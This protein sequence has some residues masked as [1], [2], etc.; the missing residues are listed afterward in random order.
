MKK[1]MLAG[2]MAA[3]ILWTT[4]P[5][6]AFQEDGPA[7][8]AVALA[9]ADGDTRYG[10]KNVLGEDATSTQNARR[11]WVDH[12]VSTK[13]SLTFDGVD[14][15][16]ITREAGEDFLVTYST[17]AST[18]E[19][20]ILPD[21][22]PSDTIFVLDFSMTM[23]RNMIGEY[24]TDE[25]FDTTRTK[26][27]LDAM[28]ET[29]TTLKEANGDNRVGI[30]TFCG[31]SDVLLPLTRLG[32]ITEI[33]DT[34]AEADINIV[35]SYAG[36]KK[37]IYQTEHN[38]FSVSESI[39]GVNNR[40][41]V[42]C[43]I[44]G[45][46]VNM[47][48]DW[49]SMFAGLYEALDML[50][51]AN[52]DGEN[53][54]DREVHIVVITDGDSNAVPQAVDGSEWYEKLDT[55]KYTPGGNGEAGIVFATVLMASYLKY[56]M[57]NH[58]SDCSIYTVG[59]ATNDSMRLLLDTNEYI[60]ARPADQ[61][62]KQ[63]TDYWRRYQDGTSPQ[64][65]GITFTA[66][67]DDKGNIVPESYDYVD[68]FFDTDNAEDLAD[69]F[70]TIT[71]EIIL[72]EAQAPAEVPDGA[73]PAQSGYVTYTAPLGEYMEV[74][75]VK[76]ILF[77][78]E[79]FTEKTAFQSGDTT[80][81]VFEGKVDSPVYDEKPL[82]D[83]VIQEDN[84]PMRIVYSVGLMNEVN[85]ETLAGVSP[86]Y[87]ENNMDKQGNVLFY[88]NGYGNQEISEDK[89][90]GSVTAQ[91]T[92]GNTNPFYYAPAGTVL[93]TCKNDD[94]T[95]ATEYKEGETYYV[96]QDYYCKNGDESI[97]NLLWLN[98]SDLKKDDTK[99]EALE[100]GSEQLVLSRSILKQVHMEDAR[101]EKNEGNHS[102]TADY[103]Y[104][105]TERAGNPGE[106]LAYLGNNGRLGLENPL[107]ELAIS[108]TVQ[109][110]EGKNLPENA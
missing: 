20:S 67:K 102:E 34:T 11:M 90:V 41:W 96:K 108:K 101:T 84:A 8:P 1:R 14:S 107:G 109:A 49:T 38:Y 37:V 16:P 85:R 59:L 21:N 13:N 30:V 25:A 47:L 88:C 29:V 33:D 80:K 110:A 60:E 100:D 45:G 17:L 48:S 68:E 74:K 36:N 35:G 5:A 106:F 73:D 94:Y 7:E 58:Y 55:S 92:A 65:R 27:M 24:V 50:R 56:E 70:Q 3:C 26:A 44:Q 99:V 97:Y 6:Y 105:A 32:D 95:V 2:L 77:G 71:K 54:Y 31:I 83:I 91:F 28:D 23:N 104:Y 57:A 64:M 69:A 78:G 62:A 10:Y 66:V 87:I 82:S 22:T 40:N 42:R 18:S 19:V 46:E 79:W 72:A 51:S 39:R 9:V 86:E 76:G 15:E 61:N 103:S 81:Y 4:L 89:T 43:N 75:D 98:R 12:T 63:V 53:Q 93:Y 52:S